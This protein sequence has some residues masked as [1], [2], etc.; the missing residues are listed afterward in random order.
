MTNKIP[1]PHPYFDSLNQM[2]S[3]NYICEPPIDGSHLDDYL[4]AKKFLLSYKGSQDTFNAYRRDIERLL[5]WSLLIVYGVANPPI[6]AAR[7][8]P[9]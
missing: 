6:N 7:Y 1:L 8:L 3:E 4:I 5:Q 2:L 9:N